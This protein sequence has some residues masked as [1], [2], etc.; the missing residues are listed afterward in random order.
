MT[1]DSSRQGCGA[2]RRPRSPAAAWGAGGGRGETA[3]GEEG[4]ARIRRLGALADGALG[5][6]VPADVKANYQ[7]VTPVE[8][9]WQGL[10]RYWHKR[11]AIRQKTG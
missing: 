5:P 4:P 2:A 9:S 7:L 6:D 1:T 10:A 8:Q 11:N 3:G